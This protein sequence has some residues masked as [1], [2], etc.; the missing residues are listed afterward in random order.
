MRPKSRSRGLAALGL[1]FFL[2]LGH[3]QAA[4]VGDD[5][6]MWLR[7][8]SVTRNAY[9]YAYTTGILRGFTSGCHAGIDYLSSKRKYN[10]E[11]AEDYLAGCSSNSPV[12]LAKIDDG[13]II[14][15]VTTFYNK[16]PRQRFVYISDILLKLLAGQTVDQIHREFPHHNDPKGND[17]PK[18]K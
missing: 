14:Q 8:N 3:A 15:S 6:D 7:W 13:L 9:I 16:Y 10:A 17:V 11:D 4:W 12:K 2:L 1:F 18:D 5:G